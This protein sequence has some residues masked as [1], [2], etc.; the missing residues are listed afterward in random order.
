MRSS[1]SITPPRTPPRRSPAKGARNRGAAA[2]RTAL[3]A[4]TD[5]DC[6]ADPGWL[7]AL[8]SAA[9]RAPLVAGRVDVDLSPHPGAIERFEALWRF[10]QAAWVADGWAAT[11]NLLVHADAFAAIGGFD[12][13]WRHIGEDADFCLRAGRGGFALGY[14]AEAVIRHAA[15][16]DLRPFLRRCFLHGYSANQAHY[17]LGTGHRAWH[18][19]A[20]LV[21][22]RRALALIGRDR[23]DF[24]P[25]EA[26][27]MGIVARAGYAARIA[28]SMWSEAVHAR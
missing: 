13:A 1:S 11:A 14:A 10:N 12:T 8:L 2:A 20:P 25:A 22:G 19:P 6:V 24:A 15:E 5:A 16:R 4:F 26:R 21:S 9:G 18:D 17:R 28:G 3:Y 27:I 23:A 7:E